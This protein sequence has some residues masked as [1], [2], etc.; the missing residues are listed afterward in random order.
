M[1]SPNP[2]IDTM[3]SQR[4]IP[5]PPGRS[6]AG[7]GLHLKSSPS[8]KVLKGLARKVLGEEVRWVLRSV[9]LDR[10]Q[11]LVGDQLLK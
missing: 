6:H 8:A 2:K 3:K 1:E 11:H 4:R 10:S 7:R 5:A 9:Y